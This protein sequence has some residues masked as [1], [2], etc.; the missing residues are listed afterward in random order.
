MHLWGDH[1]QY[2]GQR[3]NRFMIEE[4]A[5]AAERRAE[6]RRYI[7]ALVSDTAKWRHIDALMRKAL[8]GNVNDREIGME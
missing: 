7:D 1:T 8:N 2:H 6:E 4:Q 5:A 3:P